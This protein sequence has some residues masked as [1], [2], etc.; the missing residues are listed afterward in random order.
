MAQGGVLGNQSKVGYS[1]TLSPVAYVKLTQLTNVVIPG[2][3]FDK[4]DTSI[5]GKFLKRNMPGMGD[6]SETEITVLSD[7][8]SDE[9]RDLFDL[10]QAGTTVGWIIEVPDVRGIA[11]TFIPF[12]FNGWIKNFK[13]GAPM[14]DKQTLVI[15]VIFDGDTFTM[16]EAVASVLP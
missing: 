4:I 3:E 14:N 13:P 8:G 12:T 15:T 11:T 2:L 9:Q 7:L 5:H 16:G 6:V 1:P 10:N